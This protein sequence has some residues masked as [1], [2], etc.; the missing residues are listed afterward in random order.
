MNGVQVFASVGN[1]GDGWV[2][3]DEEVRQEAEVFKVVA[4]TAHGRQE[5][6]C[7]FVVSV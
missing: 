3:R 5:V 1:A 2:K 7:I 4:S 6:S